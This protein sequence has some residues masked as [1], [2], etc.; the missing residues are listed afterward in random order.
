ML[1]PIVKFK[2]NNNNKCLF[3]VSASTIEKIK[4]KSYIYIK[5]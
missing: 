3:A 5:I 1:R 4:V 2:F